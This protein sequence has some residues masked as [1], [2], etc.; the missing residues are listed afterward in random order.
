[1]LLEILE[2]IAEEQKPLDEEPK[3]PATE[4][5][6]LELKKLIAHDY[7]RDA[8]FAEYVAF[9]EIWNENEWED[10]YVFFGDSNISWYCYSRMKN[11][12]MELD[13]PSGDVINKFSSL[14]ELLESALNS[15]CE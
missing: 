3:L 14:G 5:E 10:D 1:M 15:V 11:A 13:K 9:L 4:T 2:P 8:W 7:S 6:I 12:F